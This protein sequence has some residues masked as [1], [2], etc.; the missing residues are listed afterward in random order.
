MFSFWYILWNLWLHVVRPVGVPISNDFWVIRMLLF[1]TL[2]WGSCEFQAVM[3]SVSISHELSTRV[4]P[5]SRPRPILL[6]FG[7]F[8]INVYV[9]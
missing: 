9:V 7:W 2:K 4:G 3:P 8:F 5:G 6:V 1:S